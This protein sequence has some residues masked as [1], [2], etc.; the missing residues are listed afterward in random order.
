MKLQSLRHRIIHKDPFAYSAHPH[1]AILPNG[2][3]VVVFNKSQRRQFILHPP[4]DP[5]FYNVLIRSNDGG[6][7]WTWPQ[8]VPGYD[9]HGVECAGLTVISNGSLLLNQWRFK[10]YPID[11]ANSIRDLEPITYPDEWGNKLVGSSHVSGHLLS[12]DQ[13]VIT[14][15]ARANDGTFVHSSLDGGRTW[16]STVRLNT[17]PYSGGYGIRGGIQLQNGTIVLPLSDVPNYKII[18][19]VFSNDNGQT[20]S[21]PVQAARTEGKDFEEPSLLKLNSNVLLM[22]M[23]ENTTRYLYM[24]RSG[25]D[26]ATWT[27]PAQTPILGCPPQLIQLSSGNLF[28]TFGYRYPPYSIRGVFSLDDGNTWM[29]ENQVTIRGDLPNHDLGY[30]VTLIMRDGS[31]L[32]IYYGQ[33]SDGIT[34]IWATSFALST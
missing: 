34:C 16:A 25:D 22:L 19:L 21:N 1:C 7:T 15:W 13:A 20:W 28:C 8:T 3:I 14:P 23:R 32:T 24:C 27:R 11:T 10:W 17:S 31:F 18:F 33:D 4:Q 26:G 5:L 9:W 2:E 29:V 12:Q 6:N 30:P